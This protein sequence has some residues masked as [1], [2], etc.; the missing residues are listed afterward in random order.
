MRRDAMVFKQNKNDALGD[1]MTNEIASDRLFGW[2][3]GV[4]LAGA[5]VLNALSY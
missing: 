1:G 2:V 3:L 5:L 4:S